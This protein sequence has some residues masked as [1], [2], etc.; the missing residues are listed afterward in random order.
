VTEPD[1]AI[2]VR[3]CLDGDEQ[4]AREFVTRFQSAV[5]AICYRMLNQREDAEDVAQDVFA[6]AFRSLKGWDANRPLRPWLLAIA[7]NRCRTMLHQRARAVSAVPYFPTPAVTPAPHRSKELA[8]E[9]EAA[10]ADLRE[11]YRLS[12]SLFYQEE[13]GC[14]E[15]GK[16]LDCPESTVKTW[17]HRARRELAE[18]LRRR[19]VIP[20][21]EH[22]L[23]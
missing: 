17:L 15:I 13:L 23:H 2:L 21:A 3:R 7:V 22:Q 14:A 16:I 20:Y 9:L 8:E 6:R 1:D 11:E 19:G 18:R 12:F 4:A 5:F 10:I